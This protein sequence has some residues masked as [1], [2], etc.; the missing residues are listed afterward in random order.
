MNKF[1][2]WNRDQEQKLNNFKGIFFAFSDEQFKEGMQ[3]IGLTET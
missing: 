1:F 3:K 2:V